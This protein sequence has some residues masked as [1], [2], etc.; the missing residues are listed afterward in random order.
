MKSTKHISDTV[1]KE[2]D[3][4][5]KAKIWLDGIYDKNIALT[6]TKKLENVN[7]NI[8]YA[9]DGGVLIIEIDGMNC[10]KKV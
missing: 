7:V 5:F 10:L 4:N 6:K 8:G 2:S 3:T 9:K 1:I